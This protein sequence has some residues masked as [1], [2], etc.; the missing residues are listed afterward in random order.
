[1]D[2]SDV[3]AAAQDTWG[4]IFHRD[5]W[6]AELQQQ[7]DAVQRKLFRYGPIDMTVARMNEA[8]LGELRQA[9]LEFV[10]AADASP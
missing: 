9:I 8:E 7:S 4:A 1:V 2:R 6:P 5:A 10:D 3:L